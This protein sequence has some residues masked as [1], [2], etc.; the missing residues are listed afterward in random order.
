MRLI[1]LFACLA[2]CVHGSR[3]KEPADMTVEYE[4]DFSMATGAYKLQVNGGEPDRNE[5]P[6]TWF[7][8]Y[9]GVDDTARGELTTRLTES[10]AIKGP[11]GRTGVLT[12]AIETKPDTVNYFGFV[13]W[14]NGEG[15]DI[16]MNS[17]PS[18]LTPADLAR[19]WIKFHYRAINSKDK[20][21]TGCNWNVRF[22]PQSE[23]AYHKRADF[24]TLE[25][26]A[27]WKQFSAPLSKAGN[28]EAFLEAVNTLHPEKYKLA[29]GQQGPISNYDVG[30]TL[31][32]D[33]FQVLLD[34]PP[35][36]P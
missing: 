28:L 1:T 24:G 32:I 30:D 9:A 13:T 21:K 8:P 12:F 14:G 3:I 35:E 7:H 17:W 22:E 29:I 31:V 23:G 20:T 15:G 18:P 25:A 19:T 36:K 2:G 26:T 6:D 34:L 33:N 4:N 11:D 5:E 16:L 27:K 10:D